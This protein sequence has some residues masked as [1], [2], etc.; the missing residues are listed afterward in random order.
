MGILRNN[1]PLKRAVR[2]CC[3]IDEMLLVCHASSLTVV[4]LYDVDSRAH[5]LQTVWRSSASAIISQDKTTVIGPCVAYKNS[6]FL[7]KGNELFTVDF[8]P[9]EEPRIHQVDPSFHDDEIKFLCVQQRRLFSV[10]SKLVM[11]NPQY[12]RR[13]A[14]LCVGMEISTD[15]LPLVDPHGTHK[16]PQPRDV[17]EGDGG[18]EKEGGKEKEKGADEEAVSLAARAQKR[19]GGSGGLL[20]LCERSWWE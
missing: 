17:E 8:R 9:K 15:D 19:A 10:S 14:G 7:A 18:G 6:A 20:L 13:Y 2:S 1:L 11:H 12:S 3:V 4:A 16:K 5:V